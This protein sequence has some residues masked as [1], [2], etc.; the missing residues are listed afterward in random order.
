[1][2]IPIPDDWDGVSTCR[3]AICWPDSVK[4]RA[5][6]SGLVELPNQGRFWDF[7]TGN[8]LLLRAQFKPIYDYNFDLKE[9]YMACNDNGLIDIAE[10]IRAL[11]VSNSSSLSSAASCSC[12]GQTGYTQGAITTEGGAVPIFGN[13]P[14][15]SRGNDT[16]P[17]GYDDIEQ[18]RLDKCS[19]ATALVDGM[20]RSLAYLQALDL[21]NLTALAG[22]IGAAMAGLSPL[23]VFPPAAIIVMITALG[24]LAGAMVV[25]GDV[26]AWAIE[27]REW[28]ICQLYTGESTEA[29]VS[30]ISDALDALIATLP[31][32]GP[33][34][35]AI[36]TIVLILLNGDSLNRLMT[37]EGASGLPAGECS[38]CEAVCGFDFD[39]RTLDDYGFAI[40]N[41]SNVSGTDAS[42][43]SGGV[44][45]TT[46]VTGT[47]GTL[48]WRNSAIEPAE[49]V[50]GARFL[51]YGYFTTPTTC[52]IYFEFDDDLGE[53]VV[54]W[55]EGSANLGQTI[56]VDLAS[57]VGRVVT[58]VYVYGAW[59]STG[60][61]E[62]SLQYLRVSC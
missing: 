60:S 2:Q 38:D 15:L 9:V 49:I 33:V 62:F 21:F 51:S 32:S 46:T 44:T 8:F 48:Y 18:A 6:L 37:L 24:F 34:G 31:T 35:W 3:W 41:E 4:W 16:L 14:P 26:R 43:S 25:L 56:D 12:G 19:I 58:G 7:S 22:I 59:G 54:I 52:Y 50:S 61:K 55:A 20:I 45:I 23:L 47:P 1:M 13:Q 27:N 39:F 53:L 17:P 5:I 40:A 29:I 57:F 30:A 11:A 10:A 42:L 28:L 36:K